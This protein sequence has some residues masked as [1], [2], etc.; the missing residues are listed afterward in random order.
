[1]SPQWEGDLVLGSDDNSGDMAEDEY[2]DWSYEELGVLLQE[3]AKDY[4][5][6][7]RQSSLWASLRGCFTLADVLVL[8]TAGTKWCNAIL[9]GEIAEIWFFIMKKR[10]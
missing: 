4:I 3:G 6:D 9:Y 2:E 5:S 8:R 1:M 7:V 10:W